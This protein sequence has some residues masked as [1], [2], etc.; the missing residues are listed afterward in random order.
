MKCEFF[1]KHSSAFVKNCALALCSL[2][3]LVFSLIN[4]G[5]ACAQ[6]FSVDNEPEVTDVPGT[7]VYLGVEPAN[8]DYKGPITGGQY[9]FNG[10]LIRFRLESYGINLF[11]ASGGEITGL[12]DISY[13]DAGLKA[14]YGINI[15]RSREVIIQIPLQLITNITSAVNRNVVGLNTQF[16][17]GGLVAGIGG[18][19]GLRPVDRVRFRFNVVPSY[20]FSFATGNTFGGSLTMVEGQARMFVDRIFGELGLSLGYD[21]SFKGYDIEED[22]F[23]YNLKTHSILLGI[24]F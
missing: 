1:I 21:Y 17:Q 15:L 2:G 3:V 4:P 13:F 12:D 8:F 10:S 7:A 16:Q 24:T 9:E 5:T 20:G 22:I 23:D 18:Y 11:L 19:I 14:G 6:M